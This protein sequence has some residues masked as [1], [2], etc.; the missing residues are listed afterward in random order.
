MMNRVFARVNGEFI[1]VYLD[2]LNVYSRNFNE[3]LKHLREVF[4]RLRQAGLR[5]KAKKCHFFKKE[6]AFLGHIVGADGVKPDPDKISAVKDH[7]VPKNIRELRQ[8]IGLASYYRKFVEGFASIAAPLNSLLRKSEAYKWLD[9]HQQAFKTLKQRLISSPILVHPDFDQPFMI[10]TDAS[11]TGLGAI[12]SQKDDEDRER[13]VRYA[14]RR[15]SDSERNYS[16]TNL[17]CLGVVWAVKH[18]RKYITGT[19]FQIITDHSAIKSLMKTINPQGQ[20]ARWIIE[21]QNYDFDIVHKS[22]RTHSNVDTLS[23]TIY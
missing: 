2:D 3:H 14:S 21:L 20:T 17:E 22:G 19:H 11:A 1:V 6:L 4:E 13:V 16:A 9:Q 10:F 12:L 8:F 5:L 7:P 23:R 18:F 15:T